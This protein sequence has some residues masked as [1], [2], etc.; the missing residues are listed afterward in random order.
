MKINYTNDNSFKF[1]NENSFFITYRKR[2]FKNKTFIFPN[3]LARIILNLLTYIGLFF[4]W[5]FIYN[6]YDKF[7]L[8]AM[9]ILFICLFYVACYIILI[10]NF[11]VS[12]K[13]YKKFNKDETVLF[14]EKGITENNDDNTINYAW[15]NLTYMIVGE[16]SI[17]IF[18]NSYMCFR[19]PISIRKEILKAIKKYN[20]NDEFKIIDF[21]KED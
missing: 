12:Y 17:N 7:N 15:K 13:D 18:T 6:N 11:L 20:T 5:K 2:I 8:I 3:Y 1:Y 4:L 9:I 14:D 16:Y 19:Y 21:T 10:I